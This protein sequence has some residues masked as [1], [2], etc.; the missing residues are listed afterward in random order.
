MQQGNHAGTAESAEPKTKTEDI[1]DTLGD[2][3]DHAGEMANTFYRL[4]ILNLTKKATDVTAN[5]AGGL[6]SALLGVFFILFAGIALGFWL[7]ELLD[8]NALGFLVVAGFFALL[9]IIFLSIR[10]KIVFPMWRNK[11]IRKLYE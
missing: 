10:K 7:G 3:V 6:V 2:L 11:I 8:S 9:A 4:Q 5:I 1:K